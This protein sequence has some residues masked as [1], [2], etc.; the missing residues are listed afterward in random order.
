MKGKKR[1]Y[2]CVCQMSLKTRR[3]CNAVSCAAENGVK[4]VTRKCIIPALPYIGEAIVAGATW[5][6][7][8]QISNQVKTPNTG[9]PDSWHTNPGNAVS[10]AVGWR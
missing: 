4:A 6:A 1:Q 8:Q 2:G 5:W 3:V 9:D 7:A 10:W